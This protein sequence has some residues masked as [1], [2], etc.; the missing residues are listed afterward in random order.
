MSAEVTNTAIPG[1]RWTGAGPG[2][3]G[4]VP[5]IVCGPGKSRKR[6]KICSERALQWR[7]GNAA[8]RPSDD[9]QDGGIVAVNGS[10]LLKFFYRDVM[11]SMSN[12]VIGNH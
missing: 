3:V 5:L 10:V 6:L 12:L 9:N 2:E 8:G 11:V 7:V 1:G 4:T